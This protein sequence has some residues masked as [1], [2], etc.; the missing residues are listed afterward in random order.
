V[1]SAARRQ[2]ATPAAL[3]SLAHAQ[4]TKRYPVLSSQPFRPLPAPRG[5][6]PYRLELADVLPAAALDAV[7]RAGHLRFHSVGD[8]GGIPDPWPQQA[9]AAAMVSELDGAGGGGGVDFFYHLGDVV[10]GYGEEAG[11]GPQFFEPYARY[12]API[13][14]IPGN[15]D[16]DL[17][18]GSQAR[19]LD[20]FVDHFC[21][22]AAIATP[23][24]RAMCQPNVYWTLRHKWLTIVGL[25]TN[26]PDGGR[27]AEEQLEWLVR[28][29]IEAPRQAVLILALHH[30][31]Y[32]TDVIHGSNL[33]LADLFD[34]AFARAGRAPDA[35]FSGHVHSYQRFARRY[36]NRV[37]P[38]VV[39]GTGGVNNLQ[40]IALG[41]PGVP[42][43]FPGLPDVTLEA[44]QDSS[45]GYLTVTCGPGGADVTYSTVNGGVAH[46][47]DSFSISVESSAGP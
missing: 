28:E 43:S 35:V 44:Y 45:W 27:V 24:G 13:F 2:H 5:A 12:H 23:A 19:S 31:L 8:S 4:I 47:F 3:R 15:H 6:P 20:A 22:P 10:Y 9:V 21:A 29:L 18:P 36:R 33:T 17:E 42:A 11:Y 1:S 16:G 38:H 25:Y 37:I 7:E 46:E 40:E 14:A 26:V 34:E 30:C 32:S 41:V 39:A